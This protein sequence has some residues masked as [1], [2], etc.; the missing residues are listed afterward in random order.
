MSA[1]G[2]LAAP[3]SSVVRSH[4]VDLAAVDWAAVD[5]MLTAMS[6]E[7]RG[8]LGVGKDTAVAIVRTA[9]ALPRPGQRMHDNAAAGRTRRG[10]GVL[11]GE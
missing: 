2:L 3:L 9:D 5:R 6:A 8:Y 11:C 4:L 7:A 10:A 1:V